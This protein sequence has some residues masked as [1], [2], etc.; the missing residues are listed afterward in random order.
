M[1]QEEKQM[2]EAEIPAPEG[3]MALDIRKRIGIAVLCI[4]LILVSCIPVTEKA[5]SKSSF[6]ETKISLEEKQNTVL[7]MAA[8]SAATA[9]VIAAVPGDA[10]TPI[11]NEIMDLSSYF[12]VILAA[13]YLEKFL[14]V[15]MGYVS[16]RFLIPAGL[17][18]LAL[19]V[20][21]G[22]P[23]LKRAA[24]KLMVLGLLLFAVIPVSVKV[25]DLVEANF[26]DTISQVM[27]SAEVMA[28]SELD[29]A[30]ET[31]TDTE[32]E[33]AADSGD[34]TEEE[35]SLWDKAKD[36]LSDAADTVTDAADS[37]VDTVSSTVTEKIEEA[38][39][40]L[41]E[42]IEAIAVLIVTSCLIPILILLL[43]IWILR[44]I[45][46]IDLPAVNP[47]AFKG[48]VR[49]KSKK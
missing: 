40:A 9:T 30:E 28:E 5:V 32:T 35:K 33:E 12:V 26:G 6:Q 4:L 48:K 39:E 41:N 18:V 10:S 42:F 7:K 2:M 36:L 27:D 13:I 46:G 14:L 31:D 3:L 22:W 16:F 24:V 43:F 20:L 44:L 15:I 8:A 23:P 25:S 29:A 38:Q 21:L 34:E 49:F 11:A 37:V 17:A 47:G 45:A 1:E 19:F